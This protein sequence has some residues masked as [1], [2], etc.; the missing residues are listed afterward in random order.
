MDTFP[1]NEWC[2]IS[3]YNKTIREW[4]T[5]LM[6]HSTSNSEKKI[7]K[8]AQ[9]YPTARK[10]MSCNLICLNSML[11]ELQSSSVSVLILA[12]MDPLRYCHFS[13]SSEFLSRN[14]T[15]LD[16]PRLGDSA[17][18]K[19]LATVIPKYSGRIFRTVCPHL[20]SSFA[21]IQRVLS[22]RT[23]HE[24]FLTLNLL[25]ALSINRKWY[26]PELICLV[27]LVNFLRCSCIISSRPLDR[28][29]FNFRHFHQTQA[30]KC[31]VDERRMHQKRY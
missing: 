10:I 26:P 3:I 11:C 4:Q 30:C 14:I 28:S 19:M 15:L 16:W 6:V 21:I 22:F 8:I 20:P 12:F 17:S 27:K 9:E 7:N 31:S 2:A 29:K 13:M 24:M 1:L 18:M 25:N 5:L 23:T